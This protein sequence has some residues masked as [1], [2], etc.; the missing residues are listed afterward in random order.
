M[1]VGSASEEQWPSINGSTSGAVDDSVPETERPPIASIQ[2]FQQV[3]ED[4]LD[5]EDDPSEWPSIV[6]DDALDLRE[7]AA[8]E[9]S[10]DPAVSPEAQMQEADPDQ[11]TASGSLDQ[12]SKA[13]QP[14]SENLTSANGS[15]SD[16]VD[17]SIP[18]T[19]WPSIAST[20]QSQELFEQVVDAEDDP[21]E[22]PSIV[23]NDALDF[24]ES[25]AVVESLDPAMSPEAQPQ[26]AVADQISA[27]P[28]S[29]RLSNLQN[30][31]LVN[32]NN[33]DPSDQI[34][35]DQKADLVIPDL[36]LST[37]Q[38]EKP[39]QSK[40]DEVSSDDLAADDVSAELGELRFAEEEN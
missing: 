17:D 18:E 13:E 22:W 3:P 23:F 6:L 35:A 37:E 20:Q 24:R 27:S 32:L 16:G 11:I 28:S 4:V 7:S 19:A 34:T 2:Q 33:A 38:I 21:S 30:P 29:D 1:D 26:E 36:A 5:A 40:D 12:S 25:A 9:N 39:D 10:A 14:S 8:V 31:S 15:A